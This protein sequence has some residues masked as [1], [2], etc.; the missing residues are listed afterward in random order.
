M[1]KEFIF[2]TLDKVKVKGK[3]N[4][5]TIYEV[6]HPSHYLAQDNVSLLAHE[7]GFQNYLDKNFSEATVT[8]T[9]LHDKYPEDKTFKRMLEIC[10][11]FVAVPPP[12]N[13]DGTFTHK[14]K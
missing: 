13:W 9:T 1:Q 2:R 4:A 5:V 11:E 10:E 7:T 14:S 8:F 3:E 6:I 12:A